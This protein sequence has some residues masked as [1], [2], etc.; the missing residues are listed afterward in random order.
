[1]KEL[2]RNVLLYA[3]GAVIVIIPLQTSAQQGQ[4]ITVNRSDTALDEGSR[5]SLYTSAGYGSNMVYL[6][7]TI[8]Q[9]QPFGYTAVTYGYRDAL[10]ATISPV[11][12][13]SRNPFIAFFTASLIYN[14]V[15]NSWFDMS[16]GTSRYQV[17]ASLAD[18]LFR[19]FFYGD[20]SVGFDWRIMYTRLSAGRLFSDEASGFYQIRNSHYFQT[21][22]FSKNKFTF[23][24]DPY[25]NMLFGSITTA[26]TTT[27]QVVNIFPP[28]KKKGGGIQNPS[29]TTYS[30]KSGLM[31]ID[32]GIP[33]SFNSERLTIEADPGFILPVNESVQ[34]PGLKGF[35]FTLSGYFR[36]F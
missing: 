24:F 10:Y 36:I 26:E 12:L 16:A 35:V 2:I 33:V 13:S 27:G 18:T 15:F 3:F 6:G 5:H 7:S 30:T 21:A 28:R 23:S 8:S 34:Y 20:L 22:E 17:A 31:E 1:M 25:F 9:D 11:H 19:S 29:N 14:H 4:G 32:F